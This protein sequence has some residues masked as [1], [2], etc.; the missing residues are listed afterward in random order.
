MLK[1]ICAIKASR[2]K[3]FSTFIPTET[4]M[5]GAQLNRWINLLVKI[6]KVKAQQAMILK[7]LM[8]KVESWNSKCWI[9]S[10]LEIL[11]FALVENSFF[12]L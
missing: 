2:V 4:L 10:L 5:T 11:K 8:R 1:W 7:W 9:L 6:P 12:Y 3:I